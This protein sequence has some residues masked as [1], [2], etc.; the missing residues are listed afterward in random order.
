MNGAAVLLMLSTLGVDFGWQLAP[1]GKL[2][3]IIQIPPSQYEAIRNNANGVDSNIPPEVVRHIQRIRIVVGSSQLPRD[4]LP[5]NFP[6]GDLLPA[7]GTTNPRVRPRGVALPAS[8]NGFGGQTT[9]FDNA[10]ES[11]VT[12][13]DDPN[14]NPTGLPGPRD[15]PAFDNRP[16]GFNDL[17][18]PPIPRVNSD[19]PDF[20]GLDADR[21]PQAVI[22]RNSLDATSWQPNTVAPGFY[23]NGPRFGDSPFPNRQATYNTNSFQPGFGT[24]FNSPNRFGADIRNRPFDNVP[25]T[26]SSLYTTIG[27]T[28]IALCFSIGV[29]IFLGWLA[30]EYYLKY[31]E[32]F[33]SWRNVSR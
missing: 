20:G 27:F 30:W 1:D 24:N 6:S 26:V 15:E 19:A 29:N 28:V 7:Q 11:N 21:L 2:E 14:A 18:P 8:R 17:P 32:S 3:Y 31:R 5:D 9:V 10:Q 25:P 33:E 23:D 12:P 13:L 22:R 4:P 16:S